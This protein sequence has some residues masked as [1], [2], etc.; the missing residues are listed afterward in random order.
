MP[1]MFVQAAVDIF[2]P[3]KARVRDTH[4]LDGT[5]AHAQRDRVN[6]H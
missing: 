1:E 2:T 4:P 6:I 5:A 3:L